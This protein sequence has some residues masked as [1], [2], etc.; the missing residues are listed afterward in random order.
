MYKPVSSPLAWIF[1]C[2]NGRWCVGWIFADFILS[3]S[4]SLSLPTPLQREASDVWCH[5]LVWNLST[6]MQSPCLPF[7]FPAKFC[8]SISALS[9]SANGP[10][11]SLFFQNIL[12]YFFLKAGVLFLFV[13]LL[14]GSWEMRTGGWYVQLAAIFQ[15][16]ICHY[17]VL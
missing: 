5:P 12:R 10:F 2:A 3:V 11:S 6:V 16:D 4:V 15:A 8:C 13:W 14:R 1:L 17:A 7:C 9:F